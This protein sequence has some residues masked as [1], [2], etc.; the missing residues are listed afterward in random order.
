MKPPFLNHDPQE[1]GPQ[2][3]EDLATGYWFSEVLFT[4]VEM[5]VFT[6]L[7]PTGKTVEQV[8][9]ALNSDPRG[10]GRF[11]H[12]LSAMGLLGREGPVFFN[13]KISREYLVKGKEYYQGHSVLWRRHLFSYWRGLIKC[14][15]A[16]GRVFYQPE[17]DQEQLISRV[18]RY[19]RAMD[20]VAKT[21]VREILPI[22]EGILPKGEIL[23]VGAGSGAVTAGFL[24]RFPLMRATLIDLPEVL[25]YAGELILERRLEE[26]VTCCRANIL[27]PWPVGVGRFDL[28][29]LSNVI[30]AYSEADITGVLARASECLKN[31][32]FLIIHDFFME[33]FPEKSALFDL[34]MFIN[35][36]NGRVFSENWVREELDRLGLHRTGLIPLETDTALIIASKKEESLSKLRLDPESRLAARIRGLG[37]RTV[38]PVPVEAVHVP[39]WVD[40]RCRY[41]CGQYGK[42][43][44]PPNSPS[45]QKTRE[46]LKD[47]T[48]AFLLEGEPPTRAFQRRVLEAEREAFRDGFYKAFTLW[49]GPC[50]LCDSCGGTAGGCR[51]TRDSRPS[52]EGA[53][54][55][56][57][58]TVRRAG[59]SLSP[60]KNRDDCVKYFALLLLE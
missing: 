38:C 40:L 18:R 6:L 43:H 57:F 41:G 53:G 45:P 58:K 59:L 3:L 5:E 12:A 16:G 37:F 32:G 19:V 14:L 34:N 46:L 29:I 52:M 10:V 60:L 47:Y 7:E 33:H 44:C 4:A 24:E 21:K 55:D 8:A 28:V 15:R 48:R 50:S 20:S 39:E 42:P 13:A 36:Y 31:E 49:A 54:I 17:E 56:V 11:L 27:E 26:R 23:D 25:D 1:T 22:F 35:T 51:N 30:H 2:Y 9:E